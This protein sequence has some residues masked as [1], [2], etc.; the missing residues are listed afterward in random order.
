M[1]PSATSQKDIFYFI[2]AKIDAC[3][4]LDDMIARDLL[5]IENLETS[6]NDLV[7]R[8]IAIIKKPVEELPTKT[9]G[10]TTVLVG[11]SS[12]ISN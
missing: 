10:Y 12:T 2:F 5:C 8:Y 7:D 6:I 4:K 11:S 9:F 3:H 1:A